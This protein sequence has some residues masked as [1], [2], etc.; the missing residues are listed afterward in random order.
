MIVKTGANYQE[1]GGYIELPIGF[2][3][4]VSVP[5]GMTPALADGSKDVQL[6]HSSSGTYYWVITGA[7]PTVVMSYTEA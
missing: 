4:V 5:T 7:D 2:G 6:I 3:G 1:E